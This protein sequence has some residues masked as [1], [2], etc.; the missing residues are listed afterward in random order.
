MHRVLVVPGFATVPAAALAESRSLSRLAALTPGTAA[1]DAEQ[2]LLAVLG[3]HAPVGPVAALG[4][5][6][7]VGEAFVVRADPVTFALGR[8]DVRLVGPVDDLSTAEADTLAGLLDAHFASEGLRFERPRPD[9]WFATLATPRPFLAPSPEA[10]R[11]RP[12]K[13]CLPSGPFAALWRRWMTEA[14]MLLHDHALAARARPVNG[15][16]FS[17]AGSLD[18][19]DPWP[20]LRVRAGAG[21]LADFARGLARAG[22]G[23]EVVIEDALAST[24]DFATFERVV[25][26]PALN[27]LFAHRLARLS[28]IADPGDHAAWWRA[29]APPRWRRML[30]AK[31][32]FILPARPEPAADSR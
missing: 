29:D 4:A 27:A 31:G 13:P 23:V 16:W 32:H 3:L 22:D 21:R 18:Q 7:D 19:V 9:A 5:G 14:Q 8:D 1:P 15:L 11:N 26:A 6:V 12:L 2:A 10:S 25:L 20:A 17:G 30:P 24:G 28:L